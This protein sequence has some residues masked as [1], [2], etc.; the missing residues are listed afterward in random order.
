MGKLIDKLQQVRQSSSSGIGFFGR[1]QS[2]ASK[3]RPAAIVVSLGAKDTAA[4]QSAVKA[5][6]DA[7]LFT[8]WTPKSDLSAFA[9]A[10][11]AGT[12]LL[13]VGLAEGE[14]G[15]YGTLK[16]LR[17]AGA[18]FAVV[19]A[20]ASAH[21]L[22]EDLDHFDRVV[23]F[24]TPR[25]DMA[26]LLLRVQNL[27]PAQAALL[28]VGLSASAIAKMSVA[29]YTRLKFAVESLRFP[30]L[31]T[32]DGAPETHSVPILARLGFAG[33]VLSGAGVGPDAL[34]TQVTTLRE[35]LER[36]PITHDE[37]GSALIGG[38]VG[39]QGSG[40]SPQR[41]PQREPERDPDHE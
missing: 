31:A 25:D 15:G 21:M 34:G 11:S 39:L 4:A 28:R 32:L 12:T 8:G 23:T 27:A 30:V 6:A 22:F 19:G 14:S 13:G 29:D 36:T 1:S 35:E 20:G 38:L 41:E 37:A 33:L 3:P 18:G 5:G 24:D 10:T 40:L 26:L 16:Q 9:S 2:A 7:L 17:D